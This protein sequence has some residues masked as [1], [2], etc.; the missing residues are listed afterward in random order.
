MGNGA[1]ILAHPTRDFIY[2]SLRASDIDI[3]VFRIG[4]DGDCRRSPPLMD[5]IDSPWD[6]DIDPSGQYLV[7]ANI[8]LASCAP[9][10]INQETGALTAVGGN[11][12]VAS[13]TRCVAILAAP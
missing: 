3:A 6:F 8:R 1:H 11:V 9:F 2:A 12:A 5:G 7:S 13:G 10:P 4:T